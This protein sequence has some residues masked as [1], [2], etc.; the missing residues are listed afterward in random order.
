MLGGKRSHL[1][2]CLSPYSCRSE[3]VTVNKNE[4]RLTF[5]KD[6]ELLRMFYQMMHICHSNLSHAY[7]MK[8]PAK[9]EK[10]ALGAPLRTVKMHG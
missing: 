5:Q 6:S 3:H 2:I 7:A 9:P 4:T 8:K 10:P 1:I